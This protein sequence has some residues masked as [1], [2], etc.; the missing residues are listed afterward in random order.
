MLIHKTIKSYIYIYIYTCC[1]T[2]HSLF[3]GIIISFLSTKQ[4]KAITHTKDWN[5][6]LNPT[7]PLL[8]SYEP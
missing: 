3:E 8:V 5:N 7:K 1:K 6:Q 4:S 2:L